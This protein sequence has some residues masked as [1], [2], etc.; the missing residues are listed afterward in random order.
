[1]LINC[2]FLEAASI[3]LTNESLNPK[4]A[5]M[6]DSAASNSTLIHDLLHRLPSK[7]LS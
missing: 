5:A 6:L 1:M 3:C 2:V 7:S 4:M